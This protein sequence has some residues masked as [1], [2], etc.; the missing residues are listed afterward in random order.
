MQEQ[1]PPEG[2]YQAWPEPILTSYPVV[3]D[4]EPQ[5]TGRNRLTVFFRLFL[6]LPH[7]IIVGGAGLD[8][9]FGGNQRIDDPTFAVV[10]V[11]LGILS[12]GLLSIAVFLTTFISWFAIVLAGT[13]PRGLW[14]FALFYLRWKANVS[15]Y[16]YLLRDDYPPFNEGPYPLVYEVEL[17]EHRIRWKVAIRLILIIPQAIVVSLL[18]IAWFITVVIAWFAILFTGNYPEGLY[19]FGVGVLRWDTRVNAYLFLLRDE[20]PPFSLDP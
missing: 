15:A 4:V 10:L 2:T 14:R 12:T 18:Q 16:L 1:P 19:K 5:T 20:Y 6:A 17:P 3:F 9:N 7:L 13:H 8:F 11:I